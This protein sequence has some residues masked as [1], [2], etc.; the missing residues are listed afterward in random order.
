M[1]YTAKRL[2]QAKTVEIIFCARDRRGTEVNPRPAVTDIQRANS[3]KAL[4]ITVKVLSSVNERICSCTTMD[5][6]IRDGLPVRKA[7]GM[8]HD[9]LFEVFRCTVL[10]KLL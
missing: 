5:S 2:N 8:R 3:M 7:H 1:G 4:G 9:C 6:C 10:T